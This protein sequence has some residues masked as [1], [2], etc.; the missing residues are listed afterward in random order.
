MVQI[1]FI[2][3]AGGGYADYASVQPNTTVGEFLAGKVSGDLGRYLI[4]V[5]G[6]AVARDERLKA[7]DR[8]SVTPT[9]LEG[10]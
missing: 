7:G 1:F 2:N 6:Q 5:N 4:R 10:A 8:V 9:K 3:N